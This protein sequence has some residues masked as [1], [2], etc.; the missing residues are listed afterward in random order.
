MALIA[1]AQTGLVLPA[2][3]PAQLPN[4]APVFGTAVKVMV[5][6]ELNALPCGLCW[7]VPGPVAAVESVNCCAN[8]AVTV[9][10]ALIA[11]VHTGFAL[12]AHAPDHAENTAP[13]FGTA[14]SVMDVPE[15]KLVPVGVC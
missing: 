3:A 1:K 10:L 8:V 13:E 14:V 9:V 2:H 4:V 6:P 11:K 5:V 12:P 15:A 7:I